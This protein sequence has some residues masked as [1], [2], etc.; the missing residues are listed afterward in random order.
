MWFLF[1]EQNWLQWKLRH[2]SKK[3]SF[4]SNDLLQIAWVALILAKHNQRHWLLAEISEQTWGQQWIHKW[5]LGYGLQPRK[6]KNRLF[7][8]LILRSYVYTVFFF[9]SL[10][11]IVLT[12]L[13]IYY[14]KNK[15]IALIE[16]LLSDIVLVKI[17][18]QSF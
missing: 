15:G 11:A 14:Y 16:N 3:A 8:L 6:T 7:L 2:T 10:F 13:S 1:R 9:W 18:Y 12:I 5:G 4:R 17:T